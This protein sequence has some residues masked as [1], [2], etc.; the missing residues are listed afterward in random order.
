MVF[1]AN[2][3]CGVFLIS[4]SNCLLPFYRKEIDFYMRFISYIFAII[5]YQFQEFYSIH[6]K[7]LQRKLYNLLTNNS[8]TSFFQICNIFMS[9]LNCI[10]EDFQHDVEQGV[11]R[12][13]ILA[14]FLILQR[15][16]EVSNHKYDVS[17][18][19]FCGGVFFFVFVFNQSSAVLL[20]Y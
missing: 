20:V 11:V 19:I 6:W 8:S 2:I 14:L 15:N 9:C 12:G 13:D 1:G 18:R 16:Q 4:K 10:S 17:C 5:T 3:N 7:F